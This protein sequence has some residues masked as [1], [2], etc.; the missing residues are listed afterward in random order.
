MAKIYV[1]RH[2]Q[3]QDNVNG[4]LN[5]R[6][7]MELTGLGED[8]AQKAGEKLKNANISVIYSSPSKRAKKTANIIAKE[9]G[10]DQI[11][12]LD[13]LIERDFGVLTGKPVE[14][15]SKYTDDVIEIN[16]LNYF[17]SA[18]ENESY[19]EVYARAQKVLDV[20]KKSHSDENVLLVT[21][22]ETGSM[23]KAAYNNWEWMKGIEAI[24]LHN[25]EVI[26]L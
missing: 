1:I 20:M 5:G 9:L 14:D 26:E 19:P 10:I 16:G 4:I 23:L 2:G 13:N 6:R 25:A 22:G 8:Q 7:D 11:N 12:V 24:C 18:P 15:I 3:D 21:H 17:L